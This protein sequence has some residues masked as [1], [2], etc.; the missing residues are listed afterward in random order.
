MGHSTKTWNEEE[1]NKSESGS[2]RFNKGKLPMHLIPPSAIKALAGVLEYGATKYSE[3]NWESGAEYSVPYSSLMRH[4]VAFW[5]GE[6][7]DPESGL[8]HTHHIIM[9]AAM[10]VEYETLE[11]LDDRPKVKK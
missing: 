1:A 6:N 9:N 2:L 5:E 10:L 4:L 11:G 3:R 7:L 8:P